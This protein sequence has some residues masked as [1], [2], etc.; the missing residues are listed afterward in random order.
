[1]NILPILSELLGVWLCAQYLAGPLIVKL[2]LR[3][4][5]R[6]VLPR[7]DWREVLA[8]Q[9]SQFQTSHATIIGLGFVP[10]CATGLSNL[11]A[12]LYLHQSAGVAA[13]LRAGKKHVS[14]S[15]S[16]Q[17]NNGAQFSIDNSPLPAVY[18]LQPGNL[19]YHL[20]KC[21]DPAA[22]FDSYLRI[23]AKLALLVPITRDPT[24]EL[25]AAQDLENLVLSRLI[26]ARL[27]SST[28]RK[29]QRAVTFKGAIYMAWR[30][31]WPSKPVILFFAQRRAE[32]AAA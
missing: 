9:D 19:R 21:K 25:Q 2:T 7:L 4:P 10:A 28:V 20:P 27:Y 6:Y 22:L 31:A 1:M 30:L 16:Q 24:L 11:D 23:R 17:L 8:S 15:F 3:V 26:D 32:R 12:I 18:P 14:A 13:S 29:G 5:E